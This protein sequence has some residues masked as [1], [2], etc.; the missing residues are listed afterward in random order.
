LAKFSLEFRFEA[1][2]NMQSEWS[3]MHHTYALT[4]TFPCIAGTRKLTDT[5]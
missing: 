5:Y 1:K 3:G 2:C 4:D